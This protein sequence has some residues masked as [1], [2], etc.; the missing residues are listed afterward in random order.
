MVVAAPKERGA[1]DDFP[2]SA[3]LAAWACKGDLTK[4][5]TEKYNPFLSLHGRGYSNSRNRLTG[6]RLGRGF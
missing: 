2:C 5:E 4:P 1:H 3:A 6:K